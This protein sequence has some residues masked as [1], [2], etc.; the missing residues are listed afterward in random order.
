[1]FA[2]P[3]KIGD[4]HPEREGEVIDRA[5][6]IKLYHNWF[7]QQLRFETGFAEAVEELRGKVLLCWCKPK[8]CHGDVM[9]EY[10]ERSNDV[11]T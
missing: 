1:M 2:N 4:K 5:E 9:V 8:K 6:S 3:F 10:L 7:H 11:T